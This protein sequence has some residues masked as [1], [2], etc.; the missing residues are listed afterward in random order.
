MNT[1]TIHIMR[2]DWSGVKVAY[3]LTGSYCTFAESL[4][5]MQLLADSGAELIPIMSANAYSTDTRFGTA[6]SFRARIE[7]ICGREIIHTIA[8]A[9]PIGPKRMADV[10][11]VAPCTGNTLAKL[12]WSIT[13][14]AVTTAFPTGAHST[15]I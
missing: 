11:V 8:G 2:S 6:E 9:E 5:Q 12:A 4:V 15:V 13:D 7:G 3:A 1:S 10:M 14:T